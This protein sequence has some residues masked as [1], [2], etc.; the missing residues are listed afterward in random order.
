ME[1]R[2]DV[3]EVVEI[4]QENKKRGKNEAYKIN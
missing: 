3:S 1:K 2:Y 4:P